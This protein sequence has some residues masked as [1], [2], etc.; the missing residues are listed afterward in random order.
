VAKKL[1]LSSRSSKTGTGPRSGG[2]Q[3]GSGLDGS[4]GDQTGSGRDG[5]GGFRRVPEGVG[6]RGSSYLDVSP[7]YVS[8][9]ITTD[10]YRYFCIPICINGK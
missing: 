5:S 8:R 9:I 3:T 10:I 6:C 1:K 4:G 7:Y 2:D